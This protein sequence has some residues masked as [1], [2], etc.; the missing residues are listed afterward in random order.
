MKKVKVGIIGTGNIGTDILVKIMRSDYLECGIFAGRNP[1]SEGIRFA[2]KLGVKTSFRSIQAI[3]ENPDS[4]EIVFDATSAETHK[5]HAPILKKLNKFVIDM[6]PAHIGPF[7]I[8]VL[9]LDK[10][11]EN[12]TNVNLITCGGQATVPIAEAITRVHP[13]TSY[14]EVVATIASKSAGIGT[15][16]NIDE[17]TQ[18]TKDAIIEFSHV[19][20][21]KAIIILNPAEP[22]VKMRNTI[23]ALIDNPD[24]ERLNNEITKVVEKI[25]KY[26]PGY[27]IIV[28]PILENGRVT[29]TIEVTGQGDYL[30]SYAGNLDIITCAG[31]EIAEKYAMKYM[32][33]GL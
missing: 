5:Y 16:N 23:Y 1:D 19:K 9:N 25:R 21:A 10:C 27:N 33:S 24:I 17:F 28:G 3:E 4:C 12:E 30:P 15:R 11:L 7:C 22:P 31:V 2:E 26:V 13:N 32:G 6:T 8:P 20:E 18:T 29:T 14:I